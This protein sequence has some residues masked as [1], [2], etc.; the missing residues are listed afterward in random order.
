MVVIVVLSSEPLSHQVEQNCGIL[1]FLHL[2][3]CTQ[4]HRIQLLTETKRF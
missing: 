2:K 1:G 4:H 3:A